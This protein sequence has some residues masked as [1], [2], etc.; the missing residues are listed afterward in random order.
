MMKVYLQKLIEGKD[1]DIEEMKDAI[2]KIM[3]NEVEPAMT[4]AFLTALSTKGEKPEEI[5]GAVKAMLEVAQIIDP[6][7][8]VLDIVGTGGDRSF[9]FNKSSTSA[10]VA[11]AAG[12]KVAKHGNRSVTSKCGSADFH[13]A[14][15]IKF[16][17]A[18]HFAKE[19][20]DKAGIVFMFAPVYHQ[21]MRFVGPIGKALGIKTIYN[22]LGP[23]INPMNASHMVLGVYKKE[24]VRP[25]A[26]V[27]QKRGLKHAMVVFGDDIVDEVSI[28]A[29]TYVAEF[30]ENNPILEY[31]IDPRDY[32]ISL[33]SHQD[34]VGGDPTV[35]KDIALDILNGI[36]GPKRDAVV[37]NAACA[38]HVDTVTPLDI[39]IKEAE[40]VIDSKLVL[41]KLEEFREATNDIR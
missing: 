3:K 19:V 39:A 28:S 2:L 41:K 24:L 12:V 30:E 40:N 15:G 4:G 33:S 16:D 13:E 20:L 25:V 29:K 27:L 1:L 17:F 35:N 8:D 9:S 26:E 10:L 22:I 11:A 32:G 34:I 5:V 14:L 37:L 6:G 38:I 21:A 7:Y 31:E 23:L 18:S 36:K